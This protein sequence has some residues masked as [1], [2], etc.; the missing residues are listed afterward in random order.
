MIISGL[1]LLLVTQ[2]V[3]D[4]SYDSDLLQDH[5]FYSPYE[6]SRLNAGHI[7]LMGMAALPLFSDTLSENIL[8]YMIKKMYR[9]YGGLLVPDLQA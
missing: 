7:P 3:V 9:H 4:D 8:Q 1:A 5:S 2:D 6:N